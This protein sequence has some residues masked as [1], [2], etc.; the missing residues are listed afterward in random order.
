MS[1]LMASIEYLCDQP[2]SL[3]ACESSSDCGHESAMAWRKSG[4]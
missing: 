2:Q 4:L 3:R 1:L